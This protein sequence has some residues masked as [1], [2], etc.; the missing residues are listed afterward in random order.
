MDE[1]ILPA[2]YEAEPVRECNLDEYNHYLWLMDKAIRFPAI[3]KLLPIGST[4]PETPGTWV[5]YPFDEQLCLWINS[6]HPE[7]LEYYKEHITKKKEAEMSKELT[8]VEKRNVLGLLKNNMKAVASVA[9]KHISPE[10]LLRVAYQ[11]IVKTPQLTTCN[12]LSLVNAIIEASQLGLEISGPLG[13]ATI[14]P[15]KGEATLIVEYRGKIA[16]AYNSGMVKTFSAHPVYANDTFSYEYG[17]NPNIRHI[18]ASGERGKL[19]AAYASIKYLNGG[20]DFE[21]VDHAMAMRSKE[22]SPAKGSKF[23]PWNIVADE[24]TMWVK[25]A[26]HQLSKRIPQSPELQRANMLEEMAEAGLRQDIDIIDIELEDFPEAKEPEKTE[27]Q[28]K[29][30][31]EKETKV[32]TEDPQR[33]PTEEEKIVSNFN[34][35]RQDF[36]TEFD[37]V[38]DEMQIGPDT[39]WDIVTMKKIYMRVSAKVGG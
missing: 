37:E 25:T 27:S 7:A 38:C 32:K 6:S 31:N 2:H 9:P 30:N 15:F 3:F 4:K 14:L 20:E 8:V 5:F 12:Q 13:Q 17:M 39:E 19:I 16:L 35:A 11:A 26:I 34:I 18:P 1:N 29:M 36:P 22:K 23:S 24:W 10:R 28:T 21:V 33:E